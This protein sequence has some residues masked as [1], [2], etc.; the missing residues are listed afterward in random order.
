MAL[1]KIDSK[2]FETQVKNATGP[3]IVKFFGKT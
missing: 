3:V 1:E 2:G